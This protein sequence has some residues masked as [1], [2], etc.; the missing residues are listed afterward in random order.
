MFPGDLLESTYPDPDNQEIVLARSEVERRKRYINLLEKE[1]RDGENHPLTLIVKRCL[2]NAPS[3]RPTTEELVTDLQG[4]RAD[5]EGPC[6]AITRADAVRQVVMMKEILGKD[7][8][9]REKVRELAAKDEE[10]QRLRLAQVEFI[11]QI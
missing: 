3:R 1:L 9:V 7:S 2:Q 11:H 8:G 5:I 6:G 10:I 4:I